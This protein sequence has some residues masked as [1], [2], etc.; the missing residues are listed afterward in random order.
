MAVAEPLRVCPNCSAEFEAHHGRMRF[1]RP[2]CKREFWRLMA[3]R[4][5]TMFAFVQTWRMGKR[6]ATP[7]STYAIVQLAAFADLCNAQDRR[8]G[9]NAA[10]I[11]GEKREAR[12]SVADLDL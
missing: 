10:L 7:D 12:W 6:G 5:Q 11:V 9:R 8:E 1:C 3:K 4:G 2:E